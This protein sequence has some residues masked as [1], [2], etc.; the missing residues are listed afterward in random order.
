MKRRL[1][2]KRRA[3][4]RAKDALRGIERY[5]DRGRARIYLRRLK[6]ARGLGFDSV[7]QALR[8]IR[9]P[10]D[11]FTAKDVLQATDDKGARVGNTPSE[12]GVVYLETSGNVDRL[13]IRR[14]MPAWLLVNVTKPGDEYPDGMI[15][16][17]GAPDK[18]GPRTAT[19]DPIVSSSRAK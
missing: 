3:K 13:S 10:L 18:T 1:V 17:H 15:W 19:S 14:G 11:T 4:R 5:Q 12:P 7:E 9:R 2:E 16:K 8:H 6:L